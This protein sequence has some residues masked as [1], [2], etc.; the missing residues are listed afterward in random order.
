MA[1]IVRHYAPGIPLSV[2]GLRTFVSTLQVAPEEPDFPTELAQQVPSANTSSCSTVDGGHLL[3][4]VTAKDSASPLSE[5]SFISDAT[6]Q[7]SE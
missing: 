3:P 7:R 1:A 2:E 5:G 6:R 4:S